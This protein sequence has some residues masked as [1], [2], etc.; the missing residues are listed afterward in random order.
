MF[1][2]MEA[3]E[4]LDAKWEKSGKMNWVMV[5]AYLR[6][7]SATSIA[8]AFEEIAKDPTVVICLEQNNSNA[9]Q[10][11]CWMMMELVARSVRNLVVFICDSR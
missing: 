4:Y 5:D 6:K 2:L 8:F 9:V 11:I 1:P 7:Q 10:S 3:P